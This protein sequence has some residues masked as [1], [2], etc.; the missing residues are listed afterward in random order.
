MCKQNWTSGKNIPKFRYLPMKSEFLQPCFAG[1]RFDEHTLPLEVAR[2]LAAYETLV[3][4]LA[5]HLYLQDHKDRQRVPKGFAADFQ[6][7]LQKVDEGSAKPLLAIVTAAALALGDGANIYFE[8]ARDLITECIAAPIELLPAAFPRNLLTHFNQVGRSL[9]EG[10]SLTFPGKEGEASVLTPDRRKHLVLAADKVYEREIDLSGTIGEADWE[11]STFRLRLPDGSQAVVPMPAT[12]HANA[13]IYGGRFRHQV[14]MKG[15]GSFD[16]WDN[17]K[18]VVSVESLEIQPDFQ[19]AGMLDGLSELADGWYDGQ[20]SAPDKEKLTLIYER[21]VGHYP[22]RLP[23][24]A[25]V[26]TPEGNLLFE[27]DLAG[28]PSVDLC[29]ADSTAYF[30]AFLEGGKEIEKE[31]NLL[32]AEDWSLFFAYL[33]ENLEQNPA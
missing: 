8:R 9:R 32:S 3:V 26:P 31:F 16:S 28:E 21:I 33:N 18:T 22:E 29:I 30:H 5:K 15:I 11:K 4:E 7:H 13:R 14:T 19:I 17:L 10:E 23:L 1:A 12:F 27:W 20:G 25:I 2:D 6:L 24:P